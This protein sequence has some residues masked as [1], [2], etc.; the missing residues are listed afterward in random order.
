MIIQHDCKMDTSEGE[1]LIEINHSNTEQSLSGNFFNRLGVFLIF[2]LII[3]TLTIPA[4]WV[5]IGILG[6]SNYG[7]LVNFCGW[8]LGVFI[9]AIGIRIY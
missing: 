1:R 2:I 4:Y 3:A 8:G 7:A 6:G 9:I 5:G